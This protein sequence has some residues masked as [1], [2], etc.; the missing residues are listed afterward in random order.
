LAHAVYAHNHTGSG[1]RSANQGRYGSFGKPQVPPR[2]DT[3][4]IPHDERNFSQQLSFVHWSIRGRHSVTARH[5]PRIATRTV[6]HNTV[7]EE[8]PVA[9]E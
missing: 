3:L 9:A 7:R 8:S 5:N 1:V 6:F 4:S 2:L